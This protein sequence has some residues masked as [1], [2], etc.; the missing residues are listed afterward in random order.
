MK[1]YLVKKSISVWKSWL[2]VIEEF[3]IHWLRQYIE[4]SSSHQQCHQVIDEKISN[5]I[6]ILNLRIMITVLKEVVTCQSCW[7]TERTW[8][9]LLYLMSSHTSIYVKN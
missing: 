1:R 2:Q 7:Y 8:T 4:T 6:V 5:K 9:H 3:A